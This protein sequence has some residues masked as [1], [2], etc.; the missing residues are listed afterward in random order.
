M[1]IKLDRDPQPQLPPNIK[2]VHING[3]LLVMYYGL[4]GWRQV[5]EAETRQILA[6]LKIG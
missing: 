2:I 6:E 4:T 1:D 5:S 3:Q